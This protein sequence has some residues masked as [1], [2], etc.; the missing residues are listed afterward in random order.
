MWEAGSGCW[1]REFTQ[2]PQRRVP[3]LVLKFVQDPS[4]LVRVLVARMVTELAI[5]EHC[6]LPPPL[7]FFVVEF[8]GEGLDSTRA[9]RKKVNMS[10]KVDKA[11]AIWDLAALRNHVGD[12]P[13]SGLEV[14][15]RLSIERGSQA[16]FAGRRPFCSQM[17]F[18]P[19]T[20]VVRVPSTHT[21]NRA[22]AHGDIPPPCSQ[23]AQGG[24][25]NVPLGPPM[26]S[27]SPV[28][29]KGRLVPITWVSLSMAETVKAP[30]WMPAHNW[31]S[32]PSRG[33]REGIDGTGVSCC[34]EANHRVAS[35]LYY[36]YSRNRKKY[37][38]TINR[39]SGTIFIAFQVGE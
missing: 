4:K 30:A 16:S 20:N 14:C 35:F 15:K 34:P 6:N 31:V 5:P 22:A 11:P 13:R 28:D 12:I 25:R 18:S 9:S 27:C 37:T 8:F 29:G 36:S 26:A 38:Q 24:K 1:H 23:R 7:C 21:S 3:R 33:G 2:E 17:A 32:M 39:A 10:C 19:W